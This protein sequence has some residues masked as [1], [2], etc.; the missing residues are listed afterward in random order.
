MT[1][2][3]A[4][5]KSTTISRVLRRAS[6]WCSKKV[7]AELR[8]RDLRRLALLGRLGRLQQLGGAEAEGPGED[9]VR[10]RL[11]LGVVLHHRV[12]ER[13]AREGHLVLGAGELLL[14]PE[15]VL[16]GLEVGVLLEHR[17]QAAEQIGRAHV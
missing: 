11:A 5:A 16:V 2:S 12:V 10:E 9:I 1:A 3:T 6:A 8:E 4:A 13:L 14:Q 15:H 7:R 17:E